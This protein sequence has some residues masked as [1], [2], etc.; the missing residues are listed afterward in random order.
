MEQ[1]MNQ[2]LYNQMAQPPKKNSTIL[3]D[4]ELLL[5]YQH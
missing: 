3:W 4:L 5:Q 2:P 1:N